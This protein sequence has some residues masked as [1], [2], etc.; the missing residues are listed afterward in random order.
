MDAG[1]LGCE[2]R[3]LVAVHDRKP[4]ELDLQE[5]DTPRCDGPRKTMLEGAPHALQV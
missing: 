2:G 3:R 1:C 5:Q 4:Q